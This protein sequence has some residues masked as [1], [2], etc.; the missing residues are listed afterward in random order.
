MR[1]QLSSTRSM[2]GA[3]WRKLLLMLVIA[4]VSTSATSLASAVAFAQTMPGAEPSTGLPAISPLTSGSTRPV[5]VPLGSTEI[6]VPGLTPVN[7]L[8]G[9]RSCAAPA[10]AKSPGALF[11]GGGLSGNISLSCADERLPPSALPSSSSVG[12]VG[13]PL[14]ASEIGG[15][16]IS[17]SLPLPGPNPLGSAGSS[18]TSGNR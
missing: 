13:I 7:P 10:T 16:G 4:T 5:G 9:S 14:G 8:Q 15:A 6:G 11:D 17:P 1:H 18:N 12:R 2:R 3:G